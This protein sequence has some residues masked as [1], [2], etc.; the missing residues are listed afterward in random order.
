MKHKPRAVNQ[1]TWSSLN[2]SNHII[3]VKMEFIRYHSVQVTSMFPDLWIY[4][5]SL[6]LKVCCL[7][8]SFNELG[9]AHTNHTAWAI[10]YHVDHVLSG[11]ALYFIVIV[12]LLIRTLGV[13]CMNTLTFLHQLGGHTHRVAWASLN[14]D[15]SRLVTGSLDA[16]VKVSGLKSGSSGCISLLLPRLPKLSKRPGQLGQSGKKCSLR[17]TVEQQWQPSGYL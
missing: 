17:I 11:T 16:S 5:C 13:W 6:G 3:A 8:C 10:V 7:W 15:A 14:H 12:A 9:K 2:L 4:A 1:S